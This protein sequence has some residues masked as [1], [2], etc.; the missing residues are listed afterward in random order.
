MEGGALGP[1][2]VFVFPKSP[3]LA[4]RVA[5]CVVARIWRD[6]RRDLQL[7]I[8]PADIVRAGAKIGAL[9]NANVRFDRDRR[10]GQDAYVFPNPDMIS[11]AQPPGERDVY[12]R[13]NDDAV[14]DGG[15]ESAEQRHPQP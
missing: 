5:H 10:E 3:S 6:D 9:A 2:P 11:D 8:F 13:A 7:E 12:I 15:A 1:R 4:V 14:P